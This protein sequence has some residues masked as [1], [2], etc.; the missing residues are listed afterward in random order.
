[1]KI[2][3]LFTAAM[4]VLAVFGMTL[5]AQAEVAQG[6]IW[7]IDL[8]DDAKYGGIVP[9]EANP[10]LIG[11]KAVIRVRLLNS[12]WANPDRKS[13][14]RP[15]SFQP[16]PELLV[17][18]E[19]LRSTMNPKL[20]LV[21]GGQPVYADFIEVADDVTSP[22]ATYT[23][24]YF[25]YVVK[26]GDLAMPAHLMSANG[27]PASS[28]VSADYALLNMNLWKLTNADG[29]EAVFHFYNGGGTPDPVPGQPQN[30]CVSGLGMGLYIKTVDFDKNYAKEAE[31]VS[32]KPVW[33]Q[34][35]RG[36]VTTTVYGLPTVVV[37]GQAESAT[38]LYVW[39]DKGEGGAT[40][41]E[42]LTTDGAHG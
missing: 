41:A 22:A 14:P 19:A 7:S 40:I 16:K 11:Q 35:Y 32:E 13:T 15:W 18:S 5:F 37:E 21:L 4:A 30:M 23:D 28:T 38:T 34:I 24:I 17:Y 1:M 33:R 10:L 26:S 12:N 42:L 2:K 20:G 39:V 29:D 36:M 9:S 8:V 31:T 6:S 3:N 25:S 27:Q